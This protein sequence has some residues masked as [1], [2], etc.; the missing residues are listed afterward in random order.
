L[1]PIRIDGADEKLVDLLGRLTSSLEDAEDATEAV[2]LLSRPLPE[3]VAIVL[4]TKF[5][6]DKYVL[7]IVYF[8]HFGSSEA[9]QLFAAGSTNKRRRLCRELSISVLV[10]QPWI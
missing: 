4:D 6:A 2:Y 10:L 5:M 3:T 7:F 8:T 9:E 1:Y